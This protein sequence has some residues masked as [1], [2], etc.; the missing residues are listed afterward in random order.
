MMAVVVVILLLTY[1]V[2][3]AD[4]AVLIINTIN[5]SGDEASK[6]RPHII[7]WGKLWDWW[8]VRC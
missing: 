4:S 3:S 1:L 2:T 8:L 5:S 6:G 7:F